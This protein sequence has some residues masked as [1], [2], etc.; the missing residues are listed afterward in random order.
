[1]E[2]SVSADQI[3]TAFTEAGITELAP[4]VY[5][6]LQT[7][8]DLLLR[9]NA[10]LSL[11]SV[12]EPDQIIQRHL[13]ECAFAATQL[14]SDVETLLD[15]GSGAGLPGIVI[16]LCR[17]EIRVTLAEAQGKKAAFLREAVR[18]LSLVA[19][20][21]DKRVEDL[22]QECTFS[23]VSL[24]AVEKM[25]LAIPIALKHTGRYLVLMTTE[26][27]FPAFAALSPE[28]N[29]LARTPLPNSRQKIL[30]IGAICSKNQ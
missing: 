18:S 13:A 16:A 4:G 6:H 30:A 25:E 8:L 22:P 21:Y 20:V 17:P 26:Q 19:E 15:Y 12:R 3:E 11:T 23:A 29:W 14:P 2:D 1:M 10:R 9:W 7:Y 27:S 5:G 28:M 24:R